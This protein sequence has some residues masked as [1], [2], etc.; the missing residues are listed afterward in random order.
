MNNRILVV[1]DEQIV[2]EVVGTY[3]RKEMYDVEIADN[4]AQAL[5]VAKEWHPDLV[6]L[7]LMLPGIDGLEVCRQLRKERDIPIIM[8]TAKGEE[9]DRVIGLEL[10]ADDYVVK[11]FS[12]RE[13]LARVKSVLRRTR[14]ATK[15]NK[16]TVLQY[17]DLVI[18]PSSRHVA[19]GGRSIR[20]TAK[21][22]DLLYLLASHPGHVFT[23]EQIV[24]EVWDS[25][26]D[27][28][29]GTVTVHIR[30]L[31]S[32]IENDPFRP[33]HIKTLWGVGYKFESGEDETE[34]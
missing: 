18:N 27:I 8:L 14:P 26:Y 22:F 4:G 34:H 31:R 3:L 12:P 24:N 30:R 13:L 2:S 21:E 20:L 32:K 19:L 16:T 6:I 5:R 17:D 15:H 9:T 7:D 1:D 28:E 10:G 33:R 11:P 23:R 25:S 29:S